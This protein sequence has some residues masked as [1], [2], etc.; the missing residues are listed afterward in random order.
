[1]RVTYQ[2]LYD[3]LLRA[4][5]TTNIEADRGRLCARLV[6]DTTRDGVYSHG[7]SM[8]PRVMKMIASG[9]VDVT[10]RPVCVQRRGAF[11]RW[12]G[13]AGIGTLNAYACM[14]AA[15]GLSRMHGIG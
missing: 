4:L 5:L 12:D 14:E 3:A 10:S 2:E 11:E 9:S 1:M 7:L 13:G 15:I 6:A 8:F